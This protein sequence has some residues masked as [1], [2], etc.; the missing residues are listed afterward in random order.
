MYT[1]DIYCQLT[2]LVRLTLEIPKSVCFTYAATSVYYLMR[3]IC[4]NVQQWSDRHKRVYDLLR[5]HRSAL[6]SKR[7]KQRFSAALMLS[8]MIPFDT[9]L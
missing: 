2:F 3:S 1:I 4:K 8:D 7:M 5:T 9:A 6:S